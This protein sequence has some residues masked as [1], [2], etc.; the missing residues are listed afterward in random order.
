[1]PTLVVLYV[2]GQR[3]LGIAPVVTR[4]A[5]SVELQHGSGGKRGDCGCRGSGCR[6]RR[7]GGRYRGGCGSGG[8]GSSGGGAG[9]H[10][11]AHC[12][13]LLFC[14]FLVASTGEAIA[15]GDTGSAGLWFGNTMAEFWFVRGGGGSSGGGDSGGGGTVAF[16]HNAGST[17]IANAHL[18]TFLIVAMLKI[19][20]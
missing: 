18:V 8:G 1:M 11:P 13:A 5:F 14:E 10:E 12:R 15:G 3:L 20:N 9:A 19:I 7:G 6:A 2:A 4:I 16:I 17:A